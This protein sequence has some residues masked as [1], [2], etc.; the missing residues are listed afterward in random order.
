MIDGQLIDEGRLEACQPVLRHADQRRGDRLVRAAFRGQRH[1]R[2][3][4]DQHEA[5]ILIAGIVQRIEAALD[6]GIIERADR[7]QPLAEQRVARGRA[8]TA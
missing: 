6:E 4:R 8:P 7:Q 2:G 3:R 5:R 1:A